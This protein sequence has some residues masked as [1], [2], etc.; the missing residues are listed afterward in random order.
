MT[1]EVLIRNEANERLSLHHQRLVFEMV[2]WI[3][4]RLAH[5]LPVRATATDLV[6]YPRVV[7]ELPSEEELERLFVF[8]DEHLQKCLRRREIAV[9]VVAEKLG[10]YEEQ[11]GGWVGFVQPG[12]AI[13]HSERCYKKLL[14]E[15]G[16]A[17]ADL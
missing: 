16:H 13:C 5:K 14:R 4:E 15:G 17:E 3:E 10:H 7:V 9:L 1:Y 6:Q 8:F 11:R 12:S 2:E